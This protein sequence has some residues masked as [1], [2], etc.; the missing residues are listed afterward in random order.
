MLRSVW[1]V[2]V[3]HDGLG[4]WC[5]VSVVY[6]MCDIRCEVGYLLG[7]FDELTLA[8]AGTH[9]CDCWVIWRFMVL[10][11]GRLWAGARE[12]LGGLEGGGSDVG[13]TVL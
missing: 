7:R 12:F 8:F 10:G 3:V 9:M 1:D 13:W 2:C 6:S 5:G 11:M 4:R